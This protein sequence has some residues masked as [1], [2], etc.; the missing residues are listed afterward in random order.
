MKPMGDAKPESAVEADHVLPIALADSTAETDDTAETEAAHATERPSGPE[1]DGNPDS[2][3]DA[4]TAPEMADP[5]PDQPEE[6]LEAAHPADLAELTEPAEEAEEAEL[7]EEAEETEEAELTE[8][9]PPRRRGRGVL[10]GTL[11]FVLA[12]AII[13][14]A[15]AIVGSLTHGFKK[16]VI[17]TYRK[18]AIFSLRTGECIDPNGQQAASVVSCAT[19]HKA[20]VFATFALPASAW[21]GAT[22]VRAAAS[23][24]CAGRLAGY[25]N[26][27]FAVSF[28]TTYVYPDE[29]AWQQGTRT[30]ICE[31]RATS[32]DLTGSVRGAAAG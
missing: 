5:E 29:V 11:V 12:L 17:V 19:A 28:A 2:D 14:G 26:P 23:S 15:F 25:L 13:G 9:A 1:G 24:G 8:E 30:V 21:P 4:Q 31:V 6:V 20:E 10:I 18:S 16:P 27:Q 3:S 32:G 7:T 22:V